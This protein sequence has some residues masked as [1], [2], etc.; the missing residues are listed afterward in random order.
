VV[1]LLEERIEPLG[2]AV[3]LRAGTTESQYQHTCLY[4]GCK[5]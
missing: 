3:G 1:S 5:Q 2:Y 4:T